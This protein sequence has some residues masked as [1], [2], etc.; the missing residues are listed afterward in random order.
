MTIQLPRFPFRL[1]HTIGC[2]SSVS[3]LSASEWHFLQQR[4][5]DPQFS[6]ESWQAGLLDRVRAGLLFQEQANIRATRDF[7]AIWALG[8]DTVFVERRNYH[9]TWSNV[10]VML[11]RYST[12]S[13]G[14]YWNR[15]SEGVEVPDSYV[16]LNGLLE[17][18]L[19]YA[20]M[21]EW[22]AAGLLTAGVREKRSFLP[23]PCAVLP[24]RC[25]FLAGYL[26][27]RVRACSVQTRTREGMVGWVV[28]CDL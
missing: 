6:V 11:R 14:I 21:T 8:M 12:G 26:S 23:L 2:L 22:Y 5:E 19:R 3:W 10:F 16:W 15:A 24:P 28:Q 7:A 9:Y 20:R 17:A 25:G 4:W 18:R 27:D 13:V 1:V